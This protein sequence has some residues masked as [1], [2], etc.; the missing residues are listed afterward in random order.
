MRVYGVNV[1]ERLY[2]EMEKK[3]SESIAKDVLEFSVRVAQFEG[4][5]I[6]E[7]LNPVISQWKNRISQSR[8]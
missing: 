3:L 2:K 7:L 8:Q 6:Q 5:N 4:E 1:R